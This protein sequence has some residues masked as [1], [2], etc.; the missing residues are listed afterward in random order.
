MCRFDEPIQADGNRCRTRHS[1]GEV[2]RTAHSRLAMLFA[3]AM[4]FIDQTIV[5]IASP[6]IA[7]EL[8]LSRGG[9]QWVINAYLLA[10]AAGSRWAA[11]WP[12]WSAPGGWCWS[13][14]S[15]SPSTSALCGFTPKGAVAETWII[16]FRV[17]QGLSAAFMIPAALAVV[18]AA[19]PVA[20]AR[21]GAGDLL[22]GQRRADR[23]RSD[24]RRLPDPVDLAGDLLDQHPGGDRRAGADLAAGIAHAA[25]P[26]RIDWRGAA[27]V[28]A[29]MGLSVFGLEQAASWG[30]AA[31]RTWACI[32][33]GLVVLACLRL[34]R[35][36]HPSAA[37][38]GPD[39]RAT[40]LRRRQRRAVLL[41]DRVRPGLLLRQRVLAGVARATTP[42]TPVLYLLMFFA[43]F[44][45][46]AQ[47]GGRILDR[48]AR[49][50]AVLIGGALGAVGFAL[51]ASQ[52]TDLS[53]GAQWWAS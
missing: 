5:A 23:D 42:T 34:R 37:D 8:S 50:R 15:A 48:A 44:A 30:W 46:A 10:L 14:S 3:V 12:T 28:A 22:R 21:Q 53:L 47:I 24:R 17:V 41:H 36:A 45:P 6:N 35:A 20:R 16:V 9:A 25:T 19:L 26:E 11:G 2:D 32:I 33:G 27:L 31:L 18:V 4:T 49:N 40:G 39:L 43:G 51:W 52:L 13:A 38:Q 7:Q 1:P 29:G